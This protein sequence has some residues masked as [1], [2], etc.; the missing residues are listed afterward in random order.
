MKVENDLRLFEFR[1]IGVKVPH[2]GSLHLRLEVISAG[3]LS[4]VLRRWE[5]PTGAPTSSQ[6]DDMIAALQD[7]ITAT[8]LTTSGVQGVLA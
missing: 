7:E 4:H 1:A 2:S 8:V 5:C 3:G 6:L